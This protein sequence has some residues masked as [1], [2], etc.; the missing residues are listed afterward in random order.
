MTTTQSTLDLAAE[1]APIKWLQY[2]VTVGR[3][4][5]ALLLLAAWKI[6]ADTAGPIY[7]AD[8]VN[9]VQ[10]IVED[11]ASGAFPEARHLVPME[12]GEYEKFL[13]AIGG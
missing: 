1:P 7:A 2:A 3:I 9:V 10:R 5:L 12:T 11:V 8:P 13:D 4:A 6:G